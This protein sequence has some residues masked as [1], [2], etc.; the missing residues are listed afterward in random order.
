MP[1][2]P[3]QTQ[4]ATSL[5]TGFIID[6]KEGLILTNYHV[7][8]DVSELVVTTND[9]QRYSA[10]VLGYDEERDIAL[11]RIESDRKDFPA[12][13][14]ANSDEVKVGHIVFAVGNPFG[15]SGTVTHVTDGD[16]IWVGGSSVT[17]MAGE[18][19]L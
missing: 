18:V 2:G 11:L 15:L 16:T 14:F 6:D 5:G 17:C 7:I 10:K 9:N 1:G 4:K 8:E 12:L 19:L 3:S 13:A